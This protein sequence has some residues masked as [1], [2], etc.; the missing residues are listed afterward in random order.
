MRALLMILLGWLVHDPG[1]QEPVR[2]YRL[3][4]FGATWCAPCHQQQKVFEEAKIAETLRELGVESWYLDLDAGNNRAYAAQQFGFKTI[5]AATLVEVLS[6]G[7]LRVVKRWSS[8]AMTAAQYK[9]FVN[10]Y[11]IGPEPPGAQLSLPPPD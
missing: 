3:L 8:G 6:D 2:H 11:K 7:K 9:Q 10:P 1:V 5:P 4:R